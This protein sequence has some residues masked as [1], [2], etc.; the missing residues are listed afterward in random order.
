MRPAFDTTSPKAWRYAIARLAACASAALLP[1]TAAAADYGAAVGGALPV[2]VED[3]MGEGPQPAISGSPV[4]SF[5]LL[6]TL[7]SSLTWD[8]NALAHKTARSSDMYSR[9]N[10]DVTLISRWS[11]HSLRLNVGGE[12]LLYQDHQSE[13]QGNAHVSLDAVLDFDAATKAIGYARY[14]LGHEQRGWGESFFDYRHPIEYSTTEAGLA[15]RRSMDGGWAEIGGGLRHLDYSNAERD[16]GTFLDQS[17]RTGD[18]TNAYGRLG[19]EIGGGMNGFVEAGYDSRDFGGVGTDSHGVR[20]LA[21]IAYDLTKDIR[22]E[23]AG[24]YLHQSFDTTARKTLDSYAYR[25]QLVWQPAPEWT[26]A[27]IGS[28]EVGVPSA[29]AKQTNTLV[30]ESGAR[31]D[32]AV[33]PALVVHAALG[34]EVVNYLDLDAMDQRL[35]VQFGGEYYFNPQSSVWVKYTHWDHNSGL[36]SALDYDRNQV[37]VGVRSTF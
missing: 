28:R 4:E 6:T 37:G 31:V 23:V 3:L 24:G 15:L 13:T 10:P 2:T 33:A 12:G 14:R 36:Y 19:R 7:R 9:T 16:V 22:G 5:L 30:S 8:D 21:G 18:I 27:I 1:F 20:L 29:W 32:Y 17:F 26:L 35:R 25:S 34:M 11:E